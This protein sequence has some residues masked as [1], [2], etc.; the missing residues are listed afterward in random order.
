M[1]VL[2]PRDLCLIHLIFITF[3]KISTFPLI[4]LNL[5]TP[6]PKN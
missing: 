1:N 3:F 6:L 5:E 4:Y 2:G